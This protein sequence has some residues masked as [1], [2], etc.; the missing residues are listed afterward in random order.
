[1]ARAVAREL[2][3]NLASVQGSG[4]G[5]RVIRADVEKAAQGGA[6]TAQPA[7]AA[8]QAAPAQQAAPSAAPAA[9][10]GP[11]RPG[12]GGR[13]D[14]AQQ[15]PPH[16]RTADGRVAPVGA[17]LL[18]DGADRRDGPA[19]AAGPDQRA[20]WRGRAARLGERPDRQGVRPDAAGR[21]RGERLV[22][23][24]QDPEEEADP[25][26]DRRP[27]RARPDRAGH[28]GHRSEERR[29]DRAGVARADREG[30]RRQAP[31]GRLLGRHVHGQQ[32]G[33]VRDRALHGGH[34]HRRRLP[35][36]RSARR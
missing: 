28:Q 21:P 5:G 9:A 26:R 12:P 30:A 27:D 8:P 16:H 19:G 4:P 1:M 17:A 3:V 36:W 32:P 13:G 6:Q 33:D 22:R 11:G 24:R 20:A 14:P 34:Q 23:R 7:A 18:P 31:A 2:G 35:S 25:R 29:A 10:S 15:H